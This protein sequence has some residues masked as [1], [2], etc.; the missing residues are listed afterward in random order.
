MASS[1]AKTYLS[2]EVSNDRGNRR[3]KEHFCVG[4]IAVTGATLLSFTGLCRPLAGARP[5]EL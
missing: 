2:V 4:A 3:V 1:D 5:Y